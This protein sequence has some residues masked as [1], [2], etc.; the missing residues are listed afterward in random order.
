MI[1]MGKKYQV[2][3]FDHRRDIVRLIKVFIDGISPSVSLSYI[4]SG[5]G[6]KIQ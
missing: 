1:K 4:S 2:L 3:C 6:K 5:E